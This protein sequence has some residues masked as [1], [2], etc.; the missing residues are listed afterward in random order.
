[1][2]QR[3]RL[4]TP[5]PTVF[6]IYIPM[7]MYEGLYDLSCV[8]SRL[9]AVGSR[10]QQCSAVQP[11]LLTAAAIPGSTGSEGRVLTL[12]NRGHRGFRPAPSKRGS[13]AHHGRMGK[14]PGDRARSAFLH[15]SHEQGGRYSIA[16]R[17]LGLEALER[18]AEWSVL[19]QHR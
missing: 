10:V 16:E 19:E 18:F 14:V 2:A 4:E 15:D 11:G 17:R 1:M 12:Q 6:I 3:L 13:G 5:S 9:G 7:Y 8:L